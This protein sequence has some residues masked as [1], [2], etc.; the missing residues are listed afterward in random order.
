VYGDFSCVRR[1]KYGKVWS[2]D[3]RDVD[4]KSYPLK[5]QISE[6]YISGLKGCAPPNFYT[7]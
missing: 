1:N 4:V 2:S 3:L 6:N 5:A 7:R